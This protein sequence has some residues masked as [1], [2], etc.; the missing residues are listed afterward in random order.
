MPAAHCLPPS[1]GTLSASRVIH[2]SCTQ[3][4]RCR[5]SQQ[6]TDNP[7]V[8]SR[9]R[10]ATCLSATCSAASATAKPC[11]H[12]R[13]DEALQHID[14]GRDSPKTGSQQAR[15]QLCTRQ[16]LGL[17]AAVAAA[18]ATSAITRLSRQQWQ[19]RRTA[20][21]HIHVDPGGW[22]GCHMRAGSSSFC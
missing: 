21:T 17:P 5:H 16:G 1:V 22:T 10:L 3:S 8:H 13:T 12:A 20:T 15:P 18:A 9:W 4:R 6:S 19:R 7:R 14:S 11:L 2:S